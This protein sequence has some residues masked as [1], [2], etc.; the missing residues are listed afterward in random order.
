MSGNNFLQK[1]PKL[2]LERYKKGVEEKSPQQLKTDEDLEICIFF[3]GGKPTIFF[4][5]EIPQYIQLNGLTLFCIKLPSIIL[6]T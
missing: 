1:R 4:I 3:R 2:V 5:F 6:H